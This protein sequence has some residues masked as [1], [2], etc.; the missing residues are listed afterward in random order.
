M[1]ES[2]FSCHRVQVIHLH[3]RTHECTN[4]LTPA[5]TRLPVDW[6]RL[7]HIAPSYEE[8]GFQLSQS[9]VERNLQEN[10][11]QHER[12]LWLLFS[13][14]NK[15]EQVRISQSKLERVKA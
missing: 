1:I 7:D 8:R 12:Q 13:G 2:S 9:K 10:P 5:H 15:I 14:E 6:N 3:P 4:T 11:H